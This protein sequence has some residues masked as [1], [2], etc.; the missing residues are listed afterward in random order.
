VRSLP[1][2]IGPCRPQV[3][4]RAG[5]ARGARSAQRVTRADARVASRAGGA[6]SA[7]SY[8]KGKP[9]RLPLQ[10]LAR[11]LARRDQ[12]LWGPGGVSRLR[13]RWAPT[14]HQPRLSSLISRGSCPQAPMVE[15]R[16]PSA[17]LGSYRRWRDGAESNGAK[18]A[19]GQRI[20]ARIRWRAV[21]QLSHAERGGAWPTSMLA[22]RIA[23]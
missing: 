11:L 4:P 23:P 1:R 13:P 17:Q 6:L 20:Y 2:S 18:P 14:A 19:S 21:R 3:E 5:P 16:A 9:E 12:P 22:Q 15:I 7:P 10:V 8:R